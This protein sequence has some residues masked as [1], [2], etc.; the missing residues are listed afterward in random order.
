LYDIA[1]IGRAT[2][3]PAVE[4]MF[5]DGHTLCS[6]VRSVLVSITGK[7]TSAATT[8]HHSFAIPHLLLANRQEIEDIPELDIKRLQTQETSQR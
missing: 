8:L 2:A 1:S 5:L 6:H 4:E 3:M 7:T